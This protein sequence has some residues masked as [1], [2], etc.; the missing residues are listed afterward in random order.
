[1]TQKEFAEACKKFSLPVSPSEIQWLI[2]FGHKGDNTPL[3][4]HI[5]ARVVMDRLKDCF[6]VGEY[7]TD[8]T[9]FNYISK[10]GQDSAV[11]FTISFLVDGNWISFSDV[12]STGQVEPIKSAVSGAS[13]R[14]AVWVG[15]GRELYDFPKVYLS[16]K[17]TEIPDWAYPQL[18][19]LTKRLTE[20]TETRYKIV[21]EESGT[22]KSTPTGSKSP[23]TS[24][25]STNSNNSTNKPNTDLPW[26]NLLDQNDKVK[27]ERFQLIKG[28]T[29]EEISSTYKINVKE[30]TWL[31]A[32]L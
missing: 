7:K 4:A 30:K 1:M 32:N 29:I 20:G 9:P 23:Y 10:N 15:L 6:P 28:K 2:G 26:L 11:K 14:A 5:N 18:R 21:L 3:L 17:L 24:T 19:D 22:V 13:K 25:N 8:F 31:L 12:D 16:G 27:Q